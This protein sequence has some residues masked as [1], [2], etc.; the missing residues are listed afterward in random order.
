MP[1]LD[2]VMTFWDSAGAQRDGGG[3]QV[4]GCVTDHD[5]RASCS[6]Y[7]EPAV[8]SRLQLSREQVR[9]GLAWVTFEPVSG[10]SCQREIRGGSSI[11]EWPGQCHQL[12]AA[13]VAIITPRRGM[14]IVYLFQLVAILSCVSFLLII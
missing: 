11:I 12:E 6:M 1:R 2:C 10:G 7:T 13:R 14:I 4:G 9:K 5:E 8:T 3:C